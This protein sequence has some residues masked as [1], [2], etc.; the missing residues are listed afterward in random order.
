[1]YG[2]APPWATVT[3]DGPVGVLRATDTGRQWWVQVGRFDGLGPESGTEYRDEPMLTVRPD[4]RSTFTISAPAAD[5]DAWLWNRP[6]SGPVS[7]DGDA[8]RFLAVLRE[9]V[10]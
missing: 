1:M 5:L 8:A 2:G 10:Q 7:V 4:G 3:L 9:G 6:T